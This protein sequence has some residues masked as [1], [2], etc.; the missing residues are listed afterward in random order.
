MTMLSDER[1]ASL[2][3]LAQE[4]IC[5]DRLTDEIADARLISFPKWNERRRQR[6]RMT[7]DAEYKFGRAAWG[8]G[9]QP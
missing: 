1:L 5:H 2:P 7:Q 6:I 3:R 8:S 9:R 4:I